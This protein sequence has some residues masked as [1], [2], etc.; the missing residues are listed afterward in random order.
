MDQ[1]AADQLLL[2]HCV[3]NYPTPIEKADLKAITFLREEFDRT[4]GYSDHTVGNTA[5]LTAVALGATVIEKH[6]TMDKNQPLGDHKLSAEPED[7]KLLVS[8]I[9]CVEAALGEFNRLVPEDEMKMRHPMR[10]GLVA[11]RDIPAGTTLTS[12]MLV[13]LRPQ[14]GITPVRIDEVLGKSCTRAVKQGSPLTEADL[15]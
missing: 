5:C 12:D 13:P 4:I 3:S 7:M 6:F 10:R 15:S 1:F 9:R 2:L 11:K 8:E 14:E